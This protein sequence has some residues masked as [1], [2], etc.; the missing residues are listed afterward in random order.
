VGLDIDDNLVSQLECIG[1]Y[2]DVKNPSDFMEALNQV[3]TQALNNTTVSVNLY[4]N[5][6]KP[7]VTNLNMTFTNAKNNQVLYNYY[8][9][10]NNNNLPDTFGIDPSLIYDLE[11]NSL[12][13][14]KKTNIILKA[15]KH[16]LLELDV[17]LG[18]LTLR[19]KG[20]NYYNLVGVVK[21]KNSSETLFTQY[22]NNTQ[23]YLQGEYDLEILTLPRINQTIKVEEGKNTEILIPEPGNLS[24]HFMKDI[25]MSLYVFRGSKQEWVIDIDGSG[26]QRKQQFFLQPGSYRVVYRDKVSH[27]TLS[28]KHIDFSISSGGSRSFTIN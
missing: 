2:F 21:Q 27:N 25:I 3:V 8:H 7:V 18:S 1:R 12:P 10:L 4:N 19:N 16:N 13:P 9:T 22:F 28:S 24:L 15:S 5:A 23:Q 26:N 14:V 6:K 20:T 17:P 11:I